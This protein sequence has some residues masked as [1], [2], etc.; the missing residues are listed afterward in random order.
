MRPTKLLILFITCLVICNLAVKAQVPPRIQF[1]YGG[2][3][4]WVTDV[5][6]ETDRIRYTYLNDKVLIDTLE[7]YVLESRHAGSPVHHFYC[8]IREDGFH[9]ERLNSTIADPNYE[10]KHWKNNP[11]VGEQWINEYAPAGSGLEYLYQI[12]EKIVDDSDT[13]WTLKITSGAFELI[14][15]YHNKRGLI[16][17]DEDM[18]RTYLRGAV[19]N[20]VVY[21]DTTFYTPVSVLEESVVTDYSLDQNY[22]NPFNPATEIEFAL[23]EQSDVTLKVYDILGKEIGTLATG[24]YSAGR[25]TVPFDGT[26]HASG[27]YIYKLSYGKGQSI[28]RKMTLLK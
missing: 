14:A 21:G 27:V 16:R 26:S 7:Y 15:I 8:R 3:N 2:G 17:Y 12:T 18:S 11:E 10:W 1:P 23:P 20:G 25:Y 13:S 28:T 6:F 22:P 4:I 5:F 24:S 9:V 19:I